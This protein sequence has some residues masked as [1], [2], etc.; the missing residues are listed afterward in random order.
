MRPL[1]RL[2][3]LLFTQGRLF[4]LAL[5]FL[6]QTCF[7]SLWSPQS[8]FYALALIPLFLAKVQLWFTLILSPLMIWCFGQTALLFFLLAKAASAYLPIAL[9][10]ALRPLFSFHQA[11]YARVSPLRPAPFCEFLL[12]SAAQTSLPFLFSYYLTLVL[13][14]PICPLLRLSFYLKLSG[15]SGWNCLLSPSVLSGSNISPRTLVSPK[16]RRSRSAGQMGSA[17]CALCKPLL[18]LSSYLSNPLFSDWRR[19]V[20][21]K[22]FDT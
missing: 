3:F 17:T 16:E 11:H 1:T 20:S 8:P 6:L 19:T 12:V 13:S 18:S 9:S 21:S 22:F 14:S 5:P 10:V 4:L 7:L 2:C 15:K